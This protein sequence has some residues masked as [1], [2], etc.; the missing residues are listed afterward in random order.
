MTEAMLPET[1]VPVPAMEP[2]AP[3]SKGQSYRQILRATS[4]VGGGN[5][6]IILVGLARTKA[7]AILLGP[8]GVGLMGLLLGVMTTGATLFGLGLGTSGVREI[9]STGGDLARLSAVRKTLWRSCLAMGVVGLVLLWALRAPVSRLVFESTGRSA[10]VA[11]MGVG[12][13]FSVIAASQTALLQGMRRIGDMVRAGLV[14]TTLGSL[15][16]VLI[17]WLQGTHGVRW[18]VLATPMFSVLAA[19]WYA[20]RLPRP[21]HG[22]LPSQLFW[23][24]WRKMASLGVVLMLTSLAGNATDLAV[25]SMVAHQLGIEA[26]GHFQAASAISMY[27]LGLVLGA[28]AADYFPRLTQLVAEPEKLSD[29]VNDQLEIALLLTAP[30]LLAV[31]ALAPW[32]LALLYTSEFSQAAGLMRWQ[33]LGDVL[34]VASWTVG[35]VVLAHGQGKAYLVLELTTLAVFVGCVHL[36]LPVLGLPGAGIAFALQLVYYLPLVWWISRRRYG[37]RVKPAG[38]AYLAALFAAA[39]SVSALSWHSDLAAG[40]AGLLLAACAG[41]FAVRRLASQ[42]GAFGRTSKIGRLLAFFERL[43]PRR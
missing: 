26:A 32:I 40:A 31:L 3:D 39:A 34:K 23:E 35:F 22:Q 14:A 24:H 30:I 6:L 1:G 37:F 15:A 42:A 29:A 17:V 7:L 38:L 28:M 8:S 19:V 21:A 36:L 27:Y 4:I 18:F 13:L 33:I 25:R 16:G 43:A 2:E 20:R 41:T 10:D 12:V 5:V 9:A 11:W